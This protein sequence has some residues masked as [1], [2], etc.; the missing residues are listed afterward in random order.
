MAIY[1]ENQTEIANF[2]TTRV[3]N[4]PMKGFTVEFGIGVSGPKC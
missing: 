2:Q 4:A 3:F 1:V